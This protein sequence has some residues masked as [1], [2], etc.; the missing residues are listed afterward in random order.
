[1][2][3][4]V[5]N[6]SELSRLRICQTLCALY[7]VKLCVSLTILA[8]GAH[9]KVSVSKLKGIY[10]GYDDDTLPY[11]LIGV[12]L[13]SLLTNVLT[14]LACFAS[15]QYENRK[16]CSIALRILSMFNFGLGLTLLAT[17][18]MSFVHTRHLHEAFD[19]GLRQ[20]MAEYAYSP[21][22]K[23]QLDSLQ[24]EYQCC[25]NKGHED[26]FNVG[27]ILDKFHEPMQDLPKKKHLPPHDSYFRRHRR[28]TAPELEGSSTTQDSVPFS[29]CDPKAH[30]PCIHKDITNKLK[31]ALYDY[32][33]HTLYKR[34]CGDVIMEYLGGTL[35]TAGAIFALTT[36]VIEVRPEGFLLCVWCL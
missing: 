34:G 31:H 27:W 7:F 12:G 1:M 15:Q 17:A 4:G 30:R 21:K 23:E 24:M 26:W 35:L 3:L 8:F 9:L 10:S 14:A 36:F 20:S 19:R 25:G 6:L 28:E 22:I 2:F 32:T 16:K 33:A 13:I 5:I 18:I 11:M 29:C